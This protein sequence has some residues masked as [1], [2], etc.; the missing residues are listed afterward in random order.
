MKIIKR[1]RGARNE[2]FHNKPT[3]IKFK[4]DV[5]ILLLRLGYNLKKASKIVNVRDFLNLKF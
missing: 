5:E 1:I 4:R 2:I 3:H